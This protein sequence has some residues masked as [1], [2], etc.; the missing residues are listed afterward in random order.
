[1]SFTPGISASSSRAPH[2][3]RT[4]ARLVALALLCGATAWAQ[5]GGIAPKF[6]IDPGSPKA[7]AQITP[8]SDQV[9]FTTG[10]DGVT[11]NIAAGAEQYPG[12]FIKPESGS[13]WDLTPWGRVEAKITNLGAGGLQ[14]SMRVDNK[15]DG[16]SG[17]T[18][19][20]SL[21]P[22][23]SKIIKV[24]FGYAYGF[25][26]GFQLNPGSVKDLLF[27][28]NGKK[29]APRSFRIEDL[30]ATGSTG[31][32]P[33][34]DPNTARLK[35]ENGVLLGKGVKIDAA[36]QV[37]AKE[38]VTADITADGAL[39]INF[40]GGPKKESVTFKPAMGSWQLTEAFQVQIK[41]K[42]TG[43]TP[44]TPS[45]RLESKGGSSDTI[46]SASPIPPGGEAVITVPFAA[47]VSPVVPTD[48]KQEVF[49][50]GSWS[51]NNW[52]PAAGTGTK[53]TSDWTKGVT[54]TGD[55]TPGAKSLLV[56]SIVANVPESK[57]PAW[58][59]QRPPVE[60]DWVKT[61]DE[62]FDGDAINL[63]R[64]NVY[65]DNFWDKRTHFSKDNAIVKDGKLTLHFE[66]KT[67]YHNDNPNDTKT[68]GKTDYACGYADSYGKWRQRYGYFE[69]RV[70]LPKAPG[71]WPAFW[72]MPDR[73][74]EAGAQWKR[75]SIANG[76]MEFDIL[77]FLS[78]WGPYRYNLAFHWDGY[79]KEHKSG[80]TPYHYVLPDKDGYITT[81]VY[82]VP[83][84]AVYY[85]Q[86]QEVLR[87]ASPRVSTI[88]SYVMFDMVTGGWDNQP[89][90]DAKLPDDFV[91]DYVRVWQRKDL[92]SPLDGPMPNAGLPSSLID[93]AK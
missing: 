8:S 61:L 54:L 84:L 28:A 47:V 66:K 82:W 83:G 76:G 53:F 73:G 44:V 65:T 32:K 91:I 1:M 49:G 41:L 36:K 19:G 24:I 14:L 30:Q 48:P 89:L 78:G 25:K 92:A 79:G 10:R 70:K 81:G 67:G 69:A 46:T 38:P 7:A 42:N 37:A 93:E 16:S 21:K 90:E 20:I 33:P 74:P 39:Q 29:D 77:E 59:G 56:T 80:G 12:F 58:V 71:L 18:E 52:A 23:E 87:W 55:N 15:P 5:V 86:G 4:P 63:N 51:E 64:W 13:A 27:F 60:G 72:L 68:V 43:K 50:K 6:L 85:C 22:G 40:A 45:A 3:L 57:I 62:N 75:S 17:N 34:L 35:P 31:D 11:V 88:P 9:T 26:P 2:M